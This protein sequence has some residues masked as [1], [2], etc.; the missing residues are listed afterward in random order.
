MKYFI[1]IM[2]ALT[3]TVTVSELQ[4]QNFYE[5]YLPAHYDTADSGTVSIHF[6]NN[7]F[8]KNNE[9]FGPYAEGITYIGSIIQPEVTWSLSDKFSLSAGWYLRYFYGKDNFEQSLP[10]IRARYN[11]LPGA[12]LIMG[13]LDGQLQHQYIEPMYN[14]DNYFSTNPEYGV[15]FLVDRKKFHTDIFMDWEH[16]LMPGD[17][18]QEEIGGGFLANVALNDLS[19]NRGLSA[20]FQSIIHHFGGQVDASA[21]PIQTR[22]NVALGLE[23]AFLPKLNLLNRITLSSFYIRAMDLSNTITIPFKSGYA[24]HN[25]VTFENKWIK[26]GTGWFHGYHYFAPKADYLFQSVSQFSNYYTTSGRDLITSKFEFGNEITKGVNLSIRFESY[27]DLQRKWNDFS[28]G[29]NI[30]VNAEV[31]ERKP[32]GKRD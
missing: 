14:T 6:Y 24:F 2:I 16:F 7:N 25:T 13:Q 12:R 29:L 9:Y 3:L 1:R 28:Y 17:S 32:K 10:V 31:F 22:T 30:R 8:I 27:Y 23:Y 15:Q 11:F 20:H 4:G 5:S 18:L 26:L 19:E 21:K